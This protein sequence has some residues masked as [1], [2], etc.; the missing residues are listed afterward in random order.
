MRSSLRRRLE[1]LTRSRLSSPHYFLAFVD[2]DGIVLD[3]GSA[4]SR[5]WVGRH[6]SEL[7][8][9]VKVIRG[10]DPLRMFA[11]ATSGGMTDDRT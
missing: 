6:C 2:A 5:G 11:E 9:P 10:V 8:A 1:R 4:A 7:P 3:D